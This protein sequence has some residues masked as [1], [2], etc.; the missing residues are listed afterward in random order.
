MYNIDIEQKTKQMKYTILQ[1]PSPKTKEEEANYR[2][3]A[4][5]HLDWIDEVKAS[6]YREVYSGY[7]EGDDVYAVL[8]VLFTIFNVKH[9]EDFIGHSLSVSDVVKID[10]KYYYCDSIGWEEVEMK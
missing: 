4:F 7:I 6:N 8:E 1:I 2:K 10:G 3:Y 5:A 9:P